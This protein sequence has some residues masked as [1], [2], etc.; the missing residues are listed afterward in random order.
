MRSS[1]SSG[2]VVVVD[3]D[4]ILRSSSSEGTVVCSSSLLSFGVV[5]QGFSH[6][7]ISGCARFSCVARVGVQVVHGWLVWYL[8]QRE[9]EEELHLPFLTA[10]HGGEVSDVVG[11]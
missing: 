10:T 7:G 2:S 9:V 4:H 11:F 8:E 1:S 5:V 6:R 3:K